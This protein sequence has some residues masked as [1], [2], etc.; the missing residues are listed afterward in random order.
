MWEVEELDLARKLI[1]VKLVD[2]KMEIAWPGDFGE[3]HTK[4]LERM[5]RV[6]EEDVEYPYLKQN[7]LQRLKTARKVARNTG[8]LRHSLVHLGGYTWCLFPW[9]GTR[10]FRTLRR[11]IKMKTPAQF[12]LS[13]LDF[14]GCCYF[15]FKLESGDAAG[16]VRHWN[17]IAETGIDCSELVGAQEAPSY[18]KFDGCIP[19]SL[20]RRAYVADRLRPDELERRLAEIKKEFDD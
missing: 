5:K 1:Y 2:G 6:L 12:G 7:A 8:M 4:I 3:I 17:K 19:P 15:T 11:F 13:A 18:D 16:L 14:A 9:L 20:L 10:S